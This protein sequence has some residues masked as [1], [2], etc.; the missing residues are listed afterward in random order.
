[1]SRLIPAAERIQR[2]RALIQQARDLPVPAEGGRA[3]FSYIANVKDLLRQARDLIKFI[4]MSPSATDE[5]KADVKKIYQE[6]EQADQEILHA[7]Q[8]DQGAG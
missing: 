5:M 6:A 2:A 3:D 4:P 8:G 7:A 1:M